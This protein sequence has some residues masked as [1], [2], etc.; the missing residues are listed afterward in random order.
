[1]V[2]SITGA[3]L[4]AIAIGLFRGEVDLFSTFVGGIA[5]GLLGYFLINQF[6]TRVGS[7]A[8]FFGAILGEICVLY[9]YYLTTIGAINLAYLWLN[10]IGCVLVILFSL[11]LATFLKE[12]PQV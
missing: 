6:L 12:Q 1:V 2:G 9:I 7:N 10:L 5:G 11:L 3:I 4:G 8:I